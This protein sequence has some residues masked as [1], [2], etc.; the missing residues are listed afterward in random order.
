VRETRAAETGSPAEV[1][2]TPS[3]F[4]WARQKLAAKI[5]TRGIRRKR[6]IVRKAVS[7]RRKSVFDSTLVAEKT[8]T[9][10]RGKEQAVAVGRGR[11]SMTKYTITSHYP[12]KNVRICGGK[13]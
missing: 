7:S 8:A 9:T 13:Y 6:R 3:T 10:L 4:D 1:L 2:T 11:V 5:K 12:S